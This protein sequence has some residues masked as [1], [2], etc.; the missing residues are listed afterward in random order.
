MIAGGEVL[1]LTME[2]SESTGR[3]IFPSDVFELFTCAFA[4]HR[5]ETI[6]MWCLFVVSSLGCG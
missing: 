5:E 2:P 4:G 6:A 3:N 1:V